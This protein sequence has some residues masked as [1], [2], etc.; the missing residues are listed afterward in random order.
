MENFLDFQNSFPFYNLSSFENKS[1]SFLQMKKLRKRNFQG[2]KTN[3]RNLFKLNLKDKQKFHVFQLGKCFS[4]S[5]GRFLLF[6]LIFNKFQV[7]FQW[8][9]WDFDSEFVEWILTDFSNVLP[10]VWRIHIQIPK[11]HNKFTNSWQNW[12]SS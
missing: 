1:K 10:E 7:D 4:I 5:W 11:F 3:R 12:K 9:K 2:E 8:I 6:A